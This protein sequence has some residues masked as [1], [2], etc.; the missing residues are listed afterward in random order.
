[1]AQEVL[2]ISVTDDGSARVVAR[3]LENL[4]KAGS[5]AESSVAFLKKALVGLGAAATIRQLVQMNDEFVRM[6]NTL[7]TNAGPSGIGQVNSMLSELAGIAARTRSGLGSTVETFDTLVDATER[8]GISQ[9]RLLPV[10]ETA[11]KLFRIGGQ[12]AGQAAGSVR[13]LGAALASNDFSRGISTLLRTNLDFA[14]AVAAGYGTNAEELKKFAADGRLTAE[15]FIASLESIKSSTDTTFGLTR[16]TISE[17]MTE[18]SDAVGLLIG[19]FVDTTET[20]QIVTGTISDVAGQIRTLAGDA[21]RMDRAGKATLGFLEDVIQ[22]GRVV[23]RVLQEVGTTILTLGQAGSS[24]GQVLNPA[25]LANLLS[26]GKNP[27]DVLSEGFG[28]LKE[29]IKAFPSFVSELERLS[30]APIFSRP[31]GAAAAPGNVPTGGGGGG[32]DPRSLLATGKSQAQEMLEQA[33]A[34]QTAAEA[35]AR[36]RAEQDPLIAA[37]QTYAEGLRVV[38]E[39]LKLGLTNQTE[40]ATAVKSLTTELERARSESKRA[41]LEGFEELRARLDP[42]VAIGH[43]YASAIQTINAALAANPSLQAEAARLVGLATDQQKKALEQLQ[44]GT[45]PLLDGVVLSFDR[46]LDSLV[47]FTQTG[48]ANIREFASS[49]VNDLQKIII[50]LF[51]VQSLRSLAGAVGAGSGFG[52]FLTAVA[53]GIAGARADGGP[54]SAGRPYLVGER[55]P[56]LFTPPTRGSIVPNEALG[57]G[58]NVTVVNVGDASEIPAAMATRAGEEVILNAI[59]RNAGRLRPIL[60]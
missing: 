12:D 6:T 17:S 20:G 59:Q 29:Q 31:G 8:L 7:R 50:K 21:E 39:A 3:N 37:G 49:A 32:P 4:G 25:G 9:Q 58:A 22:R 27:L 26:E 10:T 38:N 48:Q 53:N 5:K 40:A 46:A 57:G 47:N 42:A 19:R 45:K 60:G 33:K 44:S 14:N 35:F 28:P 13:A 1:M 54:V 55:G 41:A 15:S 11:L 18:A 30:V 52:G 16:A 36:L 56:E 43:E 2:H 24:L 51:L 34:A 23:I